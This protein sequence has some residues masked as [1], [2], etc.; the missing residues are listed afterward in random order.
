[1]NEK[2][3]LL[4]AVDKLSKSKCKKILCD[5]KRKDQPYIYRSVAIGSPLLDIIEKMLEDIK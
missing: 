3:V 1:M 4:N 2:E 5:A